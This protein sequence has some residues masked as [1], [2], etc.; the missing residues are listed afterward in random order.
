MG[1]QLAEVS[2][3]IG[4][5]SCVAEVDNLWSRRH[6]FAWD[7]CCS[8]GMWE[9]EEWLDQASCCW[10]FVALA[11]RCYEYCQMELADRPLKVRQAFVEWIGTS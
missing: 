2:R 4:L 6:L 9:E 3:S 8:I 7:S 1:K 11:Y 10:I 5:H